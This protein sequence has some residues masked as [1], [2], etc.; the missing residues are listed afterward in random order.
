[1]PDLG[2]NRPRLVGTSAQLDDMFVPIDMPEI[3]IRAEYTE[4]APEP[5]KSVVTELL[6]G[7]R[8]GLGQ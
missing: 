1:M 6:V 8:G 4:L 7:Q 5:F 2:V 3:R